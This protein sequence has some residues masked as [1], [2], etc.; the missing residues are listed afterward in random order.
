MISGEQS[1]LCKHQANILPTKKS[2][3]STKTTALNS[4]HGLTTG[5]RACGVDHAQWTDASSWL[6][7][8]HVF[9]YYNNWVFRIYKWLTCV[10]YVAY[11]MG[12]KSKP[13]NLCN[14][15]V[16]CQPIFII[17]AHI[18]Q[19]KFAT[20]RYIVSPPNMVCVTAL[21]CKISITTFLAHPVF[22]FSLVTFRNHDHN[23]L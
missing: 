19:R 18:H 4:K 15:F 16:Y 23:P 21:P 17:L 5:H 14:N 7:D 2:R 1:I 12:Q 11:R 8:W 10:G 3:L 20:G 22:R 9:T 13:A 6:V